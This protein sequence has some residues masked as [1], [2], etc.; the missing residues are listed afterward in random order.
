M[1]VLAQPSDVET[2]SAIE[3]A[4]VAFRMASARSIGRAGAFGQIPVAVCR[5]GTRRAVGRFVRRSLAAI[6][7]ALVAA[8][9][10]SPY[11]PGTL[12]N[13]LNGESYPN[14][15]RVSE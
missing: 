12:T 13:A 3:S 4:S 11:A 6:G 9:I 15:R 10:P 7:A 2:S 8:C 5:A 1:S 14:G